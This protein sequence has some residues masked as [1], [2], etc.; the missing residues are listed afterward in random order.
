MTNSKTIASL[1]GPSLIATGATVLLHIRLLPDIVAGFVQD[2]A[3]VVAAG[4]AVF[5]PGLAIVRFHNYWH[6]DWRVL[7]TLSGW[8]FI[9]VGLARILFPVE[10]SLIASQLIQVP[11]LLPAMALIFLALGGFLTFEAYHQG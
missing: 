10:M 1:L 9:L 4:F 6:R 3:I 5:V 2:P 8:F 11:G 7:V